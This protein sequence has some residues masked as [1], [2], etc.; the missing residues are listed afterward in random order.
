M[1]EMWVGHRKLKYV[2]KNKLESSVVP[3]TNYQAGEQ[4]MVYF[5]R[6]HECKFTFVV[7]IDYFI[8]VI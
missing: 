8:L 7:I 3:K 2:F 5:G 4:Q 1:K 6:F